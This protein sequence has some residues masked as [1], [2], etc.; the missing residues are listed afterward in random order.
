MNRTEIET[1]FEDIFDQALL[2]HGFADYMRDYLL[3]VQC[4]AD[5]RTG[6][7]PET[8]R[9]RFR[10][11]VCVE[12]KTQVTDDGWRSSLDERL[13]NYETGV[14]LDGF[15]WGVKW[16]CLYPGLELVD[17]S[18]N[19]AEWT[20][21]I[22]I[23]FHEATVT[24]EAHSISLVFSDLEVTRALPGETPFAVSGGGPDFKIPL[25]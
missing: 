1:A 21:R 22:G 19:A 16:Q 9:Y 5:P 11:C 4:T 14:D 2:F 20:E 23:D 13:I 25:T 17:G 12:V 24:T 15:V 6:I 18:T 10:Y 8:V 3:Y 7:E